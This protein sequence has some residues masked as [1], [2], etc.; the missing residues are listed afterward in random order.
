MLHNGETNVSYDSLKP[1]VKSIYFPLTT[2]AL[3]SLGP[4]LNYW[5]LSKEMTHID[6]R[7]HIRGY[8]EGALI[9]DIK[10]KA[11]LGVPHEMEREKEDMNARMDK[12]NKLS[13]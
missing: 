6:L 1:T 7:K 4:S 12:C 13:R 8:C 3:G 10:M 2:Q 11:H 5:Q 9:Q